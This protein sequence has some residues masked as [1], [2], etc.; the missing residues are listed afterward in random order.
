MPLFNEL[1]KISE[2]KQIKVLEVGPPALQGAGHNAVGAEP[3]VD[4]VLCL[5]PPLMMAWIPCGRIATES[6]ISERGRH[7]LLWK[8]QD[9]ES[10]PFV[11]APQN[12]L[13]DSLLHCTDVA[14]EDL[15]EDC[16]DLLTEALE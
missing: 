2:L 4:L 12:V 5:L 11:G 13:E 16:L 8:H 6:S 9:M 7:P 14:R 10:L 15:L 3:L 1:A